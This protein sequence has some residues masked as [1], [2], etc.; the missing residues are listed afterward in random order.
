MSVDERQVRVGFTAYV[1]GLGMTSSDVERMH[2]ELQVRLG[3]GRPSRRPGGR[4]GGPPSRRRQWVAAV[5]ALAVAA[6]VAGALWVRR[7]DPPPPPAAEP[8]LAEQLVGVWHGVGDPRLVTVFH[9]DGTELSFTDPEGLLQP[10]TDKLPPEF[11]GSATR[12]RVQGNT[13]VLTTADATGQPCDFTFTG[14]GQG[15]GQVELTPG[16]QV[17]PGCVAGATL[18]PSTIVRISPASPAGLAY[19]VAADSTLTPVST[20]NPLHGTWLLKGTGVILAVGATGSAAGVDYRIDHK[21]TIDVAADNSGTLTVPRGGQV[22]LK[23]HNPGSCA[24]T[25][26]TSTDAGDY[27]FDATVVA[28]PC[29]LFAGQ[30][31]LHWLRIH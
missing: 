14:R 7:P 26:L 16:G 9:A 28:D 15:D 1:R 3:E 2:R 30:A 17:G 19:S 18:S 21:G 22:V 6:G 25:L 8:T 23:S 20:T 13:L 10:A 4:P 24:D 12:Y 5:A 29:N 11:I 31:S 27:S